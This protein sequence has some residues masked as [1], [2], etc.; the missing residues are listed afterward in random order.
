MCAVLTTNNV[1]II[2]QEK[3]SSNIQKAMYKTPS[4][5]SAIILR[6][7]NRW[8]FNSCLIAVFMLISGGQIYAQGNLLVTPRRV[9]FD[10]QK[11][12]QELNL[13]NTGKD[14]ARYLI[15]MI[16]IRMKEDGTFEKITQP[17]SGQHF[18]STYL[19]F[20]P[21]SV[22]LAPGE[23]QAVKV[24][25]TRTGQLAPGEYRSH[26]YFRAVPVEKPLGFEDGKKDSDNLS[27]HLTPVF[28]IS[29][30][31]LIRIGTPDTE[32]KIDEVSLNLQDEEAPSLQM[33]FKRNGNMSVYGDLFVDFISDKGKTTRV[34]NIK[35][36]AVY[37]P[38][39]SRQFRV[40]LDNVKGVNYHEGKL[41][42]VYTTP[43]EAKSSKIAETEYVLK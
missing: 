9:V 1:W 4:S 28:G 22:T 32:V 19:R 25:L 40:K 31:A 8:R 3:H 13:A 34:G 41:H 18:A 16:E 2:Y 39:K 15:S 17:D 21:R 5:D 24:Q 23:A 30:P 6:T 11:S 7:K 20:F 43:A 14:T 12:T 33:A 36:I 42:I 27:V 38:T 35:G 29:I 26:L 10:G 37:T